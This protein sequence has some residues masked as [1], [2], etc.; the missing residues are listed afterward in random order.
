[1]KQKHKHGNYRTV[2]K[3]SV[4]LKKPWGLSRVSLIVFIVNG[5]VLFLFGMV[6]RNT[7]A[8]NMSDFSAE[9]AADGPIWMVGGGVAQA[10]IGLMIIARR[11][12]R[13]HEVGGRRSRRQPRRG[14]NGR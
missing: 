14:R 4:G 5:V 6:M 13:P 12:K 10:C 3:E 9:L 1:V 8:S 7:V 11:G 2:R